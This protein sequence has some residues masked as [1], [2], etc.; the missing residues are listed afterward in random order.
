MTDRS[1][2]DDISKNVDH[3]SRNGDDAGGCGMS[4]VEMDSSHGVSTLS[5][6]AMDAASTMPWH[7]RFRLPFAGGSIIEIDLRTM[8]E[9][10]WNALPPAERAGWTVLRRAGFVRAVRGLG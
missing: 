8:P 5:I 4:D 7:E 6:L 2:G 10:D 3:V 1:P 9:A